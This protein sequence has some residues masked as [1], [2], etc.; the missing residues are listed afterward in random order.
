LVLI[1]QLQYTPQIPPVPRDVGEGKEQTDTPPSGAGIQAQSISGQGTPRSSKSVPIPKKQ[2]ETLT[3]VELSPEACVPLEET[4]PKESGP[5]T[6]QELLE[7]FK[8]EFLQVTEAKDIASKLKD[9]KVLPAKKVTAIEG[10]DDENKAI[11]TLFDHLWKQ[12]DYAMAESLC[13]VMKAETGYPN[14]NTLGNTM[15]ECLQ[16]NAA[17]LKKGRD[18]EDAPRK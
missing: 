17:V 2:V 15:L 5:K 3:G 18:S 9:V 8:N 10:M 14:M 1:P 4:T 7:S 16:E 6:V 13:K 12:A 11:S